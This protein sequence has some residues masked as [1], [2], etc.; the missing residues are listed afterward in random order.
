MY[1]NKSYD[2]KTYLFRKE[3]LQIFLFFIAMSHFLYKIL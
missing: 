1:H 3:N 2:I